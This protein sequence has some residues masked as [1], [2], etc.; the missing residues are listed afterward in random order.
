M[1]RE[2]GLHV[3]IHSHIGVDLSAIE[4]ELE[5]EHYTFNAPSKTLPLD[6]FDCQPCV[7][8]KIATM[9]VQPQSETNLSVLFEGSTWSFRSRMDANGINGGYFKEE[10]ADDTTESKGT[11]YRFLRDVDV[12]DEA[13][14]ARIKD[15]IGD[16]V[17]KHL[18]MRVVIDG[19]PE[20]D[21]DVSAFIESL[22]EISCLH[23]K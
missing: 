6:V 8:K 19:E 18:A 4:D 20:A 13:G 17:F 12:S 23:F 2:E 10:G 3:E 11:Y 15:A 21:S 14:A 7:G 5:N 22:R 16:A 1:A 9:H